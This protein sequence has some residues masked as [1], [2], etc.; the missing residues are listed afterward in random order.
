MGLRYLQS[1]QETSYLNAVNASQYRRIM[2][3]FYENYERLRYQ[4]YKEDIYEELGKYPDFEDYTMEQLKSDLNSLVEWKNLTPIQD[5]KRV[6]TIADYKNKQFRYSMSEYAV[7]IERLT[8]KLENLFFEGGSL[9]TNLFGRLYQAMGEIEEVRRKPLKSINEWWI[10]LQEDFKR[11]NQNYKDYLREFYSGRTDRVLKSV[12][13]VL[14]K[15][16]FVT[17]L[18]E[19]ILELQ[20]NASKIE[21]TLAR[22][23]TELEQEVLELVIKSEM[24]IP[25]PSS[26]G[27]EIREEYVHD[28]IKGQWY[29]LKGWFQASDTGPSESSRVMEVTNEIIRKIIQNAALIM[30]LQNWGIS[31]KDDYKKFLE[32]FLECEDLTEAHKLSAHVFGIQQIQHY[33]VN[34]ARSTENIVSS[35]YDEQPMEFAL[36]PH[37]RSYKPRVDKE[38]FENKTMEKMIQREA[39]LKQVEQDRQMVMRYIENNR[40]DISKIDDC[41]APQTR[42]TL[43]R[44]ISAANMTNAKKGRTE[45]GQEFHLTKGADMC[46]L[47]CEDGDLLMPSYIFE[48]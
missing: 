18:N 41:V 26:E 46:V 12:D 30:Q 44:W 39:Y 24:S 19:F 32:M 29:A 15:D 47:K 38:G 20:M 35:T 40:L 11:L 22:I 33:K 17:Y 1:I 14:H 28:K 25:H 6:Y 9:S 23:T 3:I 16:L 36:K 48:F 2:R 45:Y 10:N 13:F 8:V 31:R 37:T 43:L 27:G 7:E 4:L 5:P 34:D 21:A 42:M